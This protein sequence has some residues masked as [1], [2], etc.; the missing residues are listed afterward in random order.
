MCKKA[1]AGQEL[2]STS[3]G[4]KRKAE[5][6]DVYVP[7]KRVSPFLN[8][9]KERKDERK[10][11]LKISI[12]KLKQLD[13]PEAF[14]RRTVL[15]NNTMKRLQTELREEKLRYRKF[16]SN[17]KKS[18]NGYGV[19]N[20]SCLSNSYLFDDPFLS[21]VHEKIT[22]DMTDTLMNN[23]FHDKP[24]DKTVDT[25]T[26]GELSV[27][28]SVTEGKQN[29]SP[30][31]PCQSNTESSNMEICDVDPNLGSSLLTSSVTVDSGD[32]SKPSFSERSI[33]VA[34]LCNDSCR[35]TLLDDKNGIPETSV[36]TCEIGTRHEIV[37]TS[38]CNNN[39]VQNSKIICH[40]NS[41]TMHCDQYKI[42]CRQY[43]SEVKSVYHDQNMECDN[44]HSTNL[45]FVKST[46][47]QINSTD[48]VQKRLHADTDNSFKTSKSAIDGLE[49]VSEN[50]FGLDLLDLD[51]KLDQKS[52]SHSFNTFLSAF[53]ISHSVPISLS[54]KES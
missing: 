33:H 6:E 50:T 36:D 26:E 16:E 40:D 53:D 31:T 24:S 9:P 39:N 23:V 46:D 25:E 8:T 34:V 5:V 13:D 14:L 27:K 42:E 20:N 2:S 47:V 38:R 35:E 7:S 51:Q 4:I 30:E 49:I 54:Y 29:N 52:L 21:G 48:N 37:R 1:G 3:Q 41:G 12:K 11:I 28:D 43:S 19:L 44:L 15:V 45:N 18:F 32:S 17:K 22:D 10:K